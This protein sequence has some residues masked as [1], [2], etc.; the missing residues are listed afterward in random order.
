MA[1]KKPTNV[2]N[3]RL[4]LVINSLVR[5]L[6]DELILDVSCTMAL[7]HK[8][9]KIKSLTRSI[10]ILINPLLSLLYSFET[11]RTNTVLEKRKG[12]LCLSV[13]SVFL[14]SLW[15]YIRYYFEEILFI[16]QYRL[17]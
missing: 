12:L 11:E 6:N 5:R 4:V 9:N 17:Y 15:I 7:I 3:L 8:N 2:S 14:N 16:S 1:I 13:H 10:Q